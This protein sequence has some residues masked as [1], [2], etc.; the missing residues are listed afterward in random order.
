[1]NTTQVMQD[2]ADQIDWYGKLLRLAEL[3]HTLVEQER[4]DDLL[5]VLDRRQKI[6]EALAGIEQR[7][8][9]VKV[10]WLELKDSVSAHDRA[11]IEGHFATLRDLLEQITRADMD[12]AML[13]QQRKL[14]VGRQLKHAASGTHLNQRYAA[15]AYAGT[16]SRLNV[17]K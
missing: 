11:S 8:K 1:M 17:E 5:V 7:L 10:E 9:P 13:L 3:Q 14:S 2:L 6:V 16:G 15:G 12:D 4:T